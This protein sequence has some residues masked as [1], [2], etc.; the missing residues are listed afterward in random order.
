MLTHIDQKNNPTM[1]DITD[2]NTTHRMATAQSQ[3]QLPEVMRSYFVAGDLILK[4]GPVFQTA[5]IAAT[6]AVKR[7]HEMIPFCHQIPVESCKVEISVDENLLVTITGRVKSTFKTGVEMEALHGVTVAALTIYDMCKALSH[8]MVLKET[9]LLYKTGGKKTLLDRPTYGL[10][11][12][13]GKSTRMGEAKALI[14]YQGKAHAGYMADLLKNYCDGVFLSAK[15]D[16]W[17]GTE[18]ESYSILEDDLENPGPIGGMLKAFKK[19]PDANWMIFACDLVHFNQN[20]I[21][22]LLASFD[23][24]A[25]ATVYKNKEGDFPE[26]LCALYTPQAQ[27]VFQDAFASNVRCPVK[28]LKNSKIHL[29]E[30]GEGINLANINTPEERQHAHH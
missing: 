25:I 22:K 13:G 15:H 9:K 29:I 26:A 11:L 4:K 21:E 17:K 14:H 23:P 1:V 16:Q 6:M 7:T 3:I 5:I 10:V 12:T 24:E 8:E 27:S 19:Y 18:L 30:Q 28:V 2:K 20:V